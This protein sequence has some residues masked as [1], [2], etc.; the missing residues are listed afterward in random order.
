MDKQQQQQKLHTKKNVEIKIRETIRVYGI[1]NVVGNIDDDDIGKL[2]GTKWDCTH[3]VRERWV[4]TTDMCGVCIKEMDGQ[5][6]S[7]FIHNRGGICV[8]IGLLICSVV[9]TL[10]CVLIFKLVV[11][12]FGSLW[13]VTKAVYLGICAAGSWDPPLPNGSRHH[14]GFCTSNWYANFNTVTLK[15]YTELARRHYMC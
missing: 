2:L 14:T 6:L 13:G 1:H 4:K 15:Q 10:V 7:W 8:R 9:W 12:F 5:Q 3:C 11:I